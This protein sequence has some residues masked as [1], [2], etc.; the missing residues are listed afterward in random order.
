ML[1][2]LVGCI[3]AGAAVWLMRPVAAAFA[4]LVLF[5]VPLAVAWIAFARSGLVLDPVVPTASILATYILGT[6]LRFRM[7]ESERRAVREAFKHYVAPEVVDRL[8]SDPGLLRLGGETRELTVLFSDLRDFTSRAETMA[9]QDV[10]RFLNALHTPLTGA[11]LA[12]RGTIDKYLGDGM[13]AFW[14]APL[15]DPDH[16][17]N[18]CR[19]ALA[20]V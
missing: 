5:A 17:E 8:A 12:T 1:G 3:L 14:N 11:V 10:V 19:A 18:A 4:L 7:A 2:V 15:D 9:A 13:M 16:V 20:M 6:L